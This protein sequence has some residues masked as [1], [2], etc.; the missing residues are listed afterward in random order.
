MSVDLPSEQSPP[1]HRPGVPSVQSAVRADLEVREAL[2]IHRY[3]T[4]LQPGNGRDALRDALEEAMDLVCY[5]KQALIERDGATVD[6]APIAGR[7]VSMAAPFTAL[8][9]VDSFGPYWSWRCLVAGYGDVCRYDNRADDDAAH[10]AALRHL[11]TEHGI[12]PATVT[13]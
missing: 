5:L 11:A 4:S 1:V 9:R 10:R 8:I 2:G 3:G 6:E 7:P 13:S 12:Y